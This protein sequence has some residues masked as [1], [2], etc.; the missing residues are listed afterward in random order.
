VEILVAADYPRLSRA[1]NVC[2]PDRPRTAL[3]R[4]L[5][6]VADFVPAKSLRC[7]RTFAGS[8]GWFPQF[9]G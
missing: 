2:H 1:L 9:K 3:C 7:R 4:G 6:A 8:S 5:G